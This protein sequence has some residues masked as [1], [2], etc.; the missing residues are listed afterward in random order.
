[1]LKYSLIFGYQWKVGTKLPFYNYFILFINYIIVDLLHGATVVDATVFN[2]CGDKRQD[3]HWTESGFSLLVPEGALSPIEASP[4]AVKA[5]ISCRFQFP[6]GFQL[7][8]ALYAISPG[9]KFKKEVKISFQHCLLIERAEQL[10]RLFII[11]AHPTGPENGYT[12]QIVS[13]GIFRIG[14]QYCEVWMSDSSMVGAAVSDDAPN[15]NQEKSSQVQDFHMAKEC[16]D[17]RLNGNQTVQESTSGVEETHSA[18]TDY[19]NDP[20]DILSSLEKGTLPE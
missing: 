6:K 5:L 14:S 1:M 18:V 10:E 16:V 19:L 9:R 17:S 4:V 7:I 12:F 8:S 11:K 3:Y 2:T 13:G 15:D 20:S